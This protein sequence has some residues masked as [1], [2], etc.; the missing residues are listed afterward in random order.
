MAYQCPKCGGAARR[1]PGG[2]A[3]AMMGGAAGALLAA[4]FSFK[5]HCP[6]CGSLKLSEMPPGTGGKVL[7]GSLA[8]VLIAVALVVGVIVLLMHMD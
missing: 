1:L 2:G 3:G 7:L 4:A 6:R 5:F 8:L